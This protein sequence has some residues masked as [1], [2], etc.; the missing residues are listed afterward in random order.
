M[1]ARLKSAK[2]F[3]YLLFGNKDKNYASAKH[4]NVNK[5]KTN[6]NFFYFSDIITETK[7]KQMQGKLARNIV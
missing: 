1:K 5:S 4:C 7:K 6:S 2:K 3:N